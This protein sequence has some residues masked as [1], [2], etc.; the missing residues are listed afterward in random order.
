MGTVMV[1]VPLVPVPVLLLV[2]L[3]GL[4]VA[5]VLAMSPVTA[6]ATKMG[7]RVVTGMTTLLLLQS[8]H[9]ESCI[10]FIGWRNLLGPPIGVTVE[11]HRPESARHSC[12]LRREVLRHVSGSRAQLLA[13]EEMIPCL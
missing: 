6:A 4:L 10:D 9:G 2:L 5:A 12:A 13:G 8:P 3:L 7:G 1:P 11:F